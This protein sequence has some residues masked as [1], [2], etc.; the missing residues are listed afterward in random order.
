[1][2]PQTS[3]GASGGVQFPRITP[4]TERCT[5]PRFQNLLSR[6]SLWAIHQWLYFSCLQSLACDARTLHAAFRP[7]IASPG[8]EACL[9]DIYTLSAP[10]RIPFNR[11]ASRSNSDQEFR[12]PWG[13]G[14]DLVSVQVRRNIL[15]E[16]RRPAQALGQ[17]KREHRGSIFVPQLAFL[18]LVNHPSG[19]SNVVDSVAEFPSGPAGPPRLT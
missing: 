14:G 19:F 2:W 7:T 15:V 4:P 9:P 13:I 5:T 12:N 1:M 8:R 11:W 16:L 10:L 17:Q 3:S 18:P 6:R